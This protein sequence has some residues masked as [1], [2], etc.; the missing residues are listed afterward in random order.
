MIFVVFFSKLFWRSGNFASSNRPLSSEVC[1]WFTVSTLYLFS[2]VPRHT[3]KPLRFLAHSEGN[4]VLL[5]LQDHKQK[6]GH[7]SALQGNEMQAWGWGYDNV[8]YQL[9]EVLH[10][11]LDKSLQLCSAAFWCSSKEITVTVSLRG[12]RAGTWSFAISCR[13]LRLWQSWLGECSIMFAVYML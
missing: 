1:V 13:F 5:I 8:I 12:V 11:R 4:P 7:S 3:D 10:A 6:R 9:S 2:M